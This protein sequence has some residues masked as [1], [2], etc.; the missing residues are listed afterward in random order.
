M[1]LKDKR[2]VSLTDVAKRIAFAKTS[3]FLEPKHFICALGV[4]DLN[5]E[6]SEA[7]KSIENWK[8]AVRNV[9]DAVS[10]DPRCALID[11]SVPQ[12]PLSEELKNIISDTKNKSLED[13]FLKIFASEIVSIK[14][15]IATVSNESKLS[16][17]LDPHYDAIN[18]FAGAI[19]T[20]HNLEEITLDSFAVGAWA[21]SKAGALKDKPSLV[22]N[23]HA[24]AVALEYL[25]KHRGWNL[26]KEKKLVPPKHQLKEGSDLSKALAESQKHANPLLALV[27]QALK[28]GVDIIMLE[29]T[30]FHE[31]G[32]AIVNLVALPQKDIKEVFIDRAHPSEGLTSFESESTWMQTPTSKDDVENNLCVALAGRVSE[33]KKAGHTSGVDAGAYQDLEDA[34]LLAWEAISIWGMDDEMGPISLSALA[35]KKHMTNG[36]LFDLAQQRLQIT[37]KKA[38]ARTEE[39]IS[40]HWREVE[41]VAKALMDK[42]KLNADEL[43]EL[44]PHLRR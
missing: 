3:E 14:K 17:N 25:I 18:R 6:L 26:P 15:S 10:F 21:A 39:I 41:I 23:L 40:G 11:G 27:N 13:F 9:C 37:M 1:L 34:T 44:V 5:T 33:Q 31:A 32:H 19:A 7:L 28:V 36:W 35:T 22:N 24:N 16:V 4:E 20:A 38:Y 2:F 43:L 42:G 12:F 29:R 30:A 8:D